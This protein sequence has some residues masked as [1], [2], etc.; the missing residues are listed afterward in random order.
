[1]LNVLLKSCFRRLRNDKILITLFCQ[2]VYHWAI[3]TAGP[4]YG[5]MCGWFAGWLNGLAWAFAVASNC[6]MTSNMI[7]FA[8]S[9]YH[10]DFEAQRWHVFVCY[11]VMSWACCFTVMFAQ[12]ALPLISRLGGFLIV[13]GF[14]VTTVVCAVMPHVTGAGYA[15]T[16]SVWRDW[17]NETGYGSDGFVFLAG[18]LN[19]AFAV[20][21]IDCVTHIAEEIPR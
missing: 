6:V 5:K 19:G 14:F 20:G 7:L 4:R 21:A 10:P 11:L 12:S 1:M 9:L 13:A 8:Y 16:D 18:M 2:T 3:A 17:D 15:S